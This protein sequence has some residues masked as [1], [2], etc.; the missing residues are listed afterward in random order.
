LVTSGMYSKIRN[1][2]YIFSLLAFTGVIRS[3]WEPEYFLILLIF[4]FMEM[5]RATKEKNVLHEKFGEE[6]KQYRKKTWF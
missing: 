6:Y 3:L 1:P 4:L 5:I 2:I